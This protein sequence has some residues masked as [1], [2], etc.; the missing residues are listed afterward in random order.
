MMIH[1]YDK[2]IKKERRADNEI[3]RQMNTKTKRDEDI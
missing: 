1:R 3:K 2:Q